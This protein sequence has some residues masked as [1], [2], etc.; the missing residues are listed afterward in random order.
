MEYN[1]GEMKKLTILIYSLASGGA[2]R[3]VSILL[4]E[5][6]QKYEIELVLMRDIIFY[7][8]PKNIKITFLENSNPTESGII[9][10]LKLPFLAYKYS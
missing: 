5:L 7:D 10:L 2:E 9:K 6:S 1:E 4:K 3:V 8:I